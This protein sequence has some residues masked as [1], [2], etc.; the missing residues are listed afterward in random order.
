M[1]VKRLF[2]PNPEAT[3]EEKQKALEALTHL[4]DAD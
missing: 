1:E 4:I 3:P 2:K